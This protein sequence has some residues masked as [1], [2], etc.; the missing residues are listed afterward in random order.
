MQV[1]ELPKSESSTISNELVKN[2]ALTDTRDA[3]SIVRDELNSQQTEREYLPDLGVTENPYYDKYN[4]LLF[5][6]HVERVER[7]TVRSSNNSSQSFH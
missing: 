7:S 2:A 4:K 1:I 5:E 3:V 6:L